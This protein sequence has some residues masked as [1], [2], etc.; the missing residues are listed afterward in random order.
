MGLTRRPHSP[1]YLQTLTQFI[2]PAPDVNTTFLAVRSGGCADIAAGYPL[3]F[4]LSTINLRYLNLSS[5]GRRCSFGRQVLRISNGNWRLL[6]MRSSP[7]IRR[8]YICS[9]VSIPSTVSPCFNTRAVS[10]HNTSRLARSAAS[11]FN[12]GQFS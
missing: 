2:C 11:A 4:K 10:S 9:S 6:G 12:T 7:K 8:P 5:S 1:L 3:D